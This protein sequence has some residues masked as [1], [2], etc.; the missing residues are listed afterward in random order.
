MDARRR[1]EQQHGDHDNDLDNR[2]H[3]PDEGQRPLG[4]RAVSQAGEN[5]ADQCTHQ[6]YDERGRPDERGQ[7]ERDERRH[8]EDDASTREN[9]SRAHDPPTIVFGGALREEQ[10]LEDRDSQLLHRDGECAHLLRQ[11]LEPKATLVAGIA[12]VAR[13][14]GDS[15]DVRRGD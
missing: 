9:P 6:R 13:Y 8:G 10:A 4:L 2:R 3:E 7:Q 5:G 14:G 1:D 11:G 15:R 12:P